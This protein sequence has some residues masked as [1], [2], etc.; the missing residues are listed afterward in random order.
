MYAWLLFS[1][2]SLLQPAMVAH[3]HI[4]STWEAEAGRLGMQRH[5]GPCS[6]FESSLGYNRP[7]LQNKKAGAGARLLEGLSPVHKAWGSI[8]SAA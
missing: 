7:C 4:H 5:A 2:F 6:E 1:I 3:A 8:P